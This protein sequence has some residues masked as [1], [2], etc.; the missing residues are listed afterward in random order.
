MKRTLLATL[1]LGSLAMGGLAAVVPAV[2]GDG[3]L[4]AGRSMRAPE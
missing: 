1:V 3:A 2:A 4:P